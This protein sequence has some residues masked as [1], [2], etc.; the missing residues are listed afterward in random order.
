MKTAVKILL[1]LAV[2]ALGSCGKDEE[3]VRV[4]GK[5]HDPYRDIPVGGASVILDNKPVSSSV[6]SA[7]FQ[8]MAT[9]ETRSDGSYELNFQKQRSSSYRLRIRKP[10][11]LLV[12][13]EYDPY[14]FEEQEEVKLS[15]AMPAKGYVRTRIQNMS[16]HNENDH[17]VFRFLH[18]D[19]QCVDCCSGA[20]LSHTGRY[21]DTSFVCAAPANSHLKY[22]Y[23]STINNNT[24]LTGPDSVLVPVM[25]T[26][27]LNVIY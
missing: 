27:P 7:G 13:R 20:F 15:F 14:V 10:E 26:I 16:S 22:E 1:V 12:E 11:Y 8:T 21:F 6:Y 4:T 23:S 9:T 19:F 5:I 18:V 24:H 25:D 2:L 17:I 3:M